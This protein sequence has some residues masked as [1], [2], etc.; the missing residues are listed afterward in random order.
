MIYK[1]KQMTICVLILAMHSKISYPGKE[2]DWKTGQK[3]RSSPVYTR[4]KQDGAVYS[5]IKGFERALWFKK[6]HGKPLS[7]HLASLGERVDDPY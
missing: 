7:I 1:H 3:L 5:R 2:H 4:L 6:A